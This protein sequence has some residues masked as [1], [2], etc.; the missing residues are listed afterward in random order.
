MKRYIIALLVLLMLGQIFA[1]VLP[2][3]SY[4]QARE[5][6]LSGNSDYQAKLAALESARWSK[7]VAL[8]SFL[9]SLSLSGTLL[10]MDPAT[11]VQTGAGTIELNNDF[12]TLNMQLT[13]VLFTG[14]KLWQAY[15]IAGLGVEMAE[16]ALTN[17]ELT[18]LTDL[19]TKYLAVLQAQELLQMSE[20]D[21]RSVQRNLELATLKQEAGLLS[22]ADILRFES[23]KASKEVS[24]LQAQ[25][26]FSLAQLALRNLLGIDFDPVPYPVTSNSNDSLLTAL[27]A[28]DAAA[29]RALSSRARTYSTDSSV[30]LKIMDKSLELSRRSYQISKASFLPTIA[31]TGSRQYQENGLDRWDFS[32]SNQIMLNVSIPLLPQVGN[33]S[34]LR[35]SYFDLQQRRWEAESTRRGIDLG[36][37]AAVLNLVSSAKQVQAA[38][39][40]L[41]Y[42][43]QTYEQMQERFRLNLISSGDLLDMDLML[44]A[45]RL[46]NSNSY[47]NYLKARI[48]LKQILGT[49]ELDTLENLILSGDNL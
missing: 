30:A 1:Q 36:V 20:L 9:P 10:Y 42:A 16:L 37:E 34:S 11:Q 39:L 6:A 38:S 33:Y 46:S 15:R 5:L 13:Q 22:G 27:Q 28:Y 45:A 4:E 31:L 17:Q 3:L 41:R 12:R 23:S 18:L 48:A 24:L 29:S 25:S 14:G 44:S 40:A 2:N 47:F 35:K 7:N 32:A 19:E 8:S 21:Y 43:E 26:A 49:T